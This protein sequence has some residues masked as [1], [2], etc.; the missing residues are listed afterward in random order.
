MNSLAVSTRRSSLICTV[1]YCLAVAGPVLSHLPVCRTSPAELACSQDPGRAWGK[2]SSRRS[3]RVGSQVP[4]LFITPSIPARSSSL[5]RSEQCS[6]D[7]GWLHWSLLRA[8][9]RP[10]LRSSSALLLLPTRYKNPVP[11]NR[12]ITP[13]NTH[14]NT[15]TRIYMHACA[16]SYAA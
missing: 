11:P 16:L 8:R 15:R 12:P 10:L 7:H 9:A 6:H 14:A 5:L 2:S 1:A 13:R 4:A 3:V